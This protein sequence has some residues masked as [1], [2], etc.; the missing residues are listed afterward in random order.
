M[1][2]IT[3]KTMLIL[4]V[5]GIGIAWASILTMPYSILASDLPV[6][7]MEYYMGFLTFLWLFFKLL[8]VWF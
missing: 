1:F 7:K 5:I 4:P 3:T 6:K 2:L 8:V